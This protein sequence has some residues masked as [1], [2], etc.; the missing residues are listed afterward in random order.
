MVHLLHH[1]EHCLYNNIGKKVKTRG[2]MKDVI[3]ESNAHD[4]E[5]YLE[6]TIFMYSRTRKI[7]S[8]TYMILSA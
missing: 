6:M 4:I 2:I 8:I 3:K 7:L 5:E 1:V